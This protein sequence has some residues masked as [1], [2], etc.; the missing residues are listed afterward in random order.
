MT[1]TVY[2]RNKQADAITYTHISLHTGAPGASGSANEL[3]GGSPAYARKAI[4]VTQAANGL[5]ELDG[6]PVF[7]IPAGET[8][9]HFAVWDGTNCTD[10]GALQNSE[11]YTGQGVYNFTEGDFLNT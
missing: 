3:S 10:T 2:K 6:V 7:D 8:I 9:T 11:N 5:R 1:A 4:T